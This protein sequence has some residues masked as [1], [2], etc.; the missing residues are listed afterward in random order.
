MEI[1]SGKSEWVSECKPTDSISNCSRDSNLNKLCWY[2]HKPFKL[3]VCRK[4]QLWAHRHC[5]NI[6]KLG[7]G[8]Y[9]CRECKNLPSPQ[10]SLDTSYIFSEDNNEEKEES[11]GDKENDYDD[12]YDSEVGYGSEEEEK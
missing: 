6:K 3:R 10:K 7:S 9:E 4:C 12:E 8:K 5:S 2:C 11:D 1:A